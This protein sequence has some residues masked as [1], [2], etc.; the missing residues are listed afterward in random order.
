MTDSRKF[1]EKACR[2]SHLSTVARSDAEREAFRGIAAGYLNLA[3]LAAG[4]EPGPA[5]EAERS[6]RTD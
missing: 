1:A 2:F 4:A 3:K 5:E 6:N